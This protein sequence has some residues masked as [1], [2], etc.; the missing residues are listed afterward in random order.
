MKRAAGFLLVAL[1]MFGPRV[2]GAVERFHASTLKFVYP[3][4]TGDFVLGFDNDSPQCTATGSPKYMFVAV[5][6]YGV[7]AEGA[8]KMF[9]TAMMAFAL[10]KQVSIA[11]D[12]ATVS[13]YINRLSV[14]N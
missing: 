4:G 14:S 11:F 12:D 1:F 13:C 7:T 3:F 6:Q 9:A 8:K 5:G 10:G 2:G